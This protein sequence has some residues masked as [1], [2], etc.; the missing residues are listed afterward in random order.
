MAKIL[1]TE[2]KNDPIPEGTFSQRIPVTDPSVSV[3]RP[4]STDR[5]Q[6]GSCPNRCLTSI[7]TT[8]KLSQQKIRNIFNC[9]F[10]QVKIVKMF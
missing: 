10:L 4:T 7:L 2:L 1:S 3:R 9:V 5:H 6:I 8:K